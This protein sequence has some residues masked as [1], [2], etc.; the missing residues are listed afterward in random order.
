MRSSSIEPAFDEFA[1]AQDRH[2]VGNRFDLGEDVGGQEH[3]LVAILRLFFMQSRNVRSIKGSRPLVGSSST[4][5]S[6][7]AA[8]AAISAIF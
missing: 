8:N 2:A 7:R 5:S 3:G 1:L 4:S 6:A